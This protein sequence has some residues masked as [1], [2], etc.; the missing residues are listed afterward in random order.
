MVPQQEQERLAG[1]ELAGAPD[2]MAITLGLG[3]DR[4]AEALLEIEEAAG[5]LFGPFHPLERR[6][7]V[8]RV[9]AEMIAIDGLITWRTDDADLFDPASSA[10]SAMIWRTGLVRPSRSTTGSI[11]F[12]TV[13]DAGYCRAPRPAAVMTTLVICTSPGPCCPVAQTAEL[14]GTAAPEAQPFMTSSFRT[15]SLLRPFP[16]SNPRVLT[17]PRSGAIFNF[18]ATMLAWGC[19]SIG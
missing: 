8:G 4:E 13:S 14:L 2:R 18:V 11:A 9:V 12:C 7:Q 10:S 15:I 6:P 3:L 5:L 16:A 19:S 17:L 1:N